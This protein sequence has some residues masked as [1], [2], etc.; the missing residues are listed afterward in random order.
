[1]PGWR[2]VYNLEVEGQPEYFANGVLVHNCAWTYGEE[3][4]SNLMFGLRLGKKPQVGVMT[5]PRPIKLLKD[6]I[7]AATTVVARSNTYDNKDNLA[8]SFMKQIIEPREGTRLGRQE[9]HA[10]ILDDNPGALWTSSMIDGL[11]VHSLPRGV[12]LIRVVVA[13]DPAGS[14]ADMA[15]FMLDAN[16]RDKNDG[17][18]AGIVVAGLGNDNHVYV[19]GDY[20]TGGSPALWGHGA[21]NAYRRHM[22]D[23]VVGESNHGG[24]NVEGVLRAVAPEISY[25]KVHASRGKQVRAEPVAARY[26]RGLV[27]HVGEF[28]KLEKEMTEW[29]PGM[30][31][32]NRL[33]A[34]VFAITALVGD[35]GE[36]TDDADL[37]AG[38]GRFY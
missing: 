20:T 26:E 14:I 13:V 29:E 25:E 34:L 18:D 5:T 33:D 38:E 3:A 31:S 32:P 16:L 19:L 11:R 35:T 24:D 30:P 8:K 36:V 15:R 23:R 4:W 6:L 12:E 37:W 17:D 1:M 28:G 7:R 21:A 9:I 27:H 2:P 22:A 10:E